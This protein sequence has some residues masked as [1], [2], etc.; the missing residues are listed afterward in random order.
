MSEEDAIYYTMNQQYE[1]ENFYWFDLKNLPQTFVT[2]LH[3][4][5]AFEIIVVYIQTCISFEY[6]YESGSY[7]QYNWPEKYRICKKL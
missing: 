4:E 3:A 2:F 7:K 5:P 1:T 6:E